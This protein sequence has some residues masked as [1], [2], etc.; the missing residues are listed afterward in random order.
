MKIGFII[1]SLTQSIP[2]MTYLVS[3]GYEVFPII[4]KKEL[5][6]DFN[7]NIIEAITNKNVLY[8]IYLEK[9]VKL[10][11]LII[12]GSLDDIKFLDTFELES[13]L[14]QNAPIILNTGNNIENENLLLSSYQ[15]LCI[16]N[17]NSSDVCENCNKIHRHLEK[18]FK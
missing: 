18:I 14:K 8:N 11:C 1:S 16:I 5:W 17:Y 13:V 2:Y 6:N 9:N 15:N 4:L 3:L 10:D 12:M 7:K